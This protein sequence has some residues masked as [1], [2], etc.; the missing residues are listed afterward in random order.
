MLLMFLVLFWVL[1]SHLLSV[2][3][4]VVFWLVT[5]LF[6][7]CFWHWSQTRFVLLRAAVCWM[8]S[9]TDHGS[10]D[11]ALVFYKFANFERRNSGHAQN[12]S[13]QMLCS[14]QLYLKSLIF[15][16]PG[17]PPASKEFCSATW[18]G[19]KHLPSHAKEI[20]FS[21]DQAALPADCR[22]NVGTRS[23]L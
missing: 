23:K 8:C 16:T 14:L 7:H 4:I 22:C 3:T 2:I 12:T 19:S 6:L 21:L 1:L 20:R 10:T 15:V 5:S 18:R 11:P 9:C 17:C 13:F